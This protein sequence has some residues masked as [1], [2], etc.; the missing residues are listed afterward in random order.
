MADWIRESNL[1]EEVDDPAEDTR[2]HQAWE[3]LQRQPWNIDT[4]LLLHKRIMRKLN[5][6]IAGKIRT[7]DVYVGN[8]RAPSWTLASGLLTEW[9]RATE[10]SANEAQIKHDH[11]QFESIHPFEDGNGRTGRMLM[12]WQRVRAGL[13]PLV[14]LA[15]ERWDYYDWFK[16]QRSR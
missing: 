10:N 6:R 1:I 8:Y 4:V 3:W 13:E 9:V 15:R 7:C 11:V 12:N 16:N 5:P 14:I 2:C